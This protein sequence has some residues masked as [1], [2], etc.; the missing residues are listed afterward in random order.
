MFDIEK[1]W[2][3][4]VWWLNVN[5]WDYS[6]DVMFRD[7]M[8]K[9]ALHG[10]WFLAPTADQWLKYEDYLRVWGKDKVKVPMGLKAAF[11]EFDIC[12]SF[13]ILIISIPITHYSQS[14]VQGGWMTGLMR[15]DLHMTHFT[16]HLSMKHFRMYRGWNM[17]YLAWDTMTVHSSPIAQNIMTWLVNSLQNMVHWSEYLSNESEEVFIPQQI[18]HYS[19]KHQHS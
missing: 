6:W 5:Y 19:Q 17:Q 1:L 18:R 10:G 4:S 11:K 14:Q 15:A 7:K 9:W 13:S 16:S 2:Y 12:F 8:V 3:V